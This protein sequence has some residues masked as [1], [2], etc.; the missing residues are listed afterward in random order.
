MDNQP[1]PRLASVPTVSL[2]GFPLARLDRHALLD[3]IFASLRAGRGGWLV[4]ANMDFIRRFVREPEMRALYGAAD[5]SVADGTPVAWACRVQGD[6]LP[7][8]VPG[9]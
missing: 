7:E 1:S 2:V 6:R 5:L 4:T 9:S 8:R 3:E